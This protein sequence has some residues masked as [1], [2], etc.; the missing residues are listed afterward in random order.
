M[1]TL[2]YSTLTLCIFAMMLSCNKEDFDWL[3]SKN[4]IYTIPELSDFIQIDK[5]SCGD[6]LE[7]E[8]KYVN[9]TGYIYASNI[10]PNEKRL[11]LYS[12]KDNYFSGVFKQIIKD[13]KVNESNSQNFFREIEKIYEQTPDSVWQ[14]VIIRVQI[15]GWD[16]AGNGWCDKAYNFIGHSIEEKK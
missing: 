4:D 8:E 9:I 15:Y 12:E 6:T 7:C 2:I 13:V 16:M 3:E 11:L 10:F 5:Y 1:K 14:P